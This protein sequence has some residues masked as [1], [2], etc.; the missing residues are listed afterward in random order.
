MC[1]LDYDEEDGS[2]GRWGGWRSNRD[3]KLRQQMLQPSP[4]CKVPASSTSHKSDSPYLLLLL[5]P[6]SAQDKPMNPM[7]GA[8]LTDYYQITMAFAYWRSGKQ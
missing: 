3:A 2:D 7:V 6:D 4:S 1:E 5:H 8:M